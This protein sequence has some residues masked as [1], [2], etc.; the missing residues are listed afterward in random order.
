MTENEKVVI[1]QMDTV[2]NR[3]IEI[4]A[5]KVTG[6]YRAEWSLD[7]NTWKHLLRIYKTPE[8]AIHNAHC[9]AFIA[10][11]HQNILNRRKAR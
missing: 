5:R 3:Q 4:Q 9:G 10:H 6:G 2:F 8:D 1:H 11:V 7:G